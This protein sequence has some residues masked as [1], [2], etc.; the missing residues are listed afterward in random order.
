MELVQQAF[1]IARKIYKH[2]GNNLKVAIL[3][4]T[5]SHQAWN[6][7]MENVQMGSLWSLGGVGSIWFEM[8]PAQTRLPLHTS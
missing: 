4:I 6:V 5:C 3:A 7:Q 2:A 8:P 1:V